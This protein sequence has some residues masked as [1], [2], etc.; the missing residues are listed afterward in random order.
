MTGPRTSGGATPTVA[1]VGRPGGREGHRIVRA[2]A[3]PDIG[4]EVCKLSRPD[5]ALLD[6]RSQVCA[7]DSERVPGGE[8][9]A[10]MDQAVQRP[11]RNPEVESCPGRIEPVVLVVAGHLPSGSPSH[12]L[13]AP[14]Q[15]ACIDSERGRQPGDHVETRVPLA[16]LQVADVR[17][18]YP[19]PIGQHLL[20][21]PQ[22]LAANTDTIAE[23]PLAG[24]RSL[25]G[26]SHP[27]IKRLR[28]I[29]VDAIGVSL[30]TSQREDW[31]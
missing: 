18:R 29:R 26:A 13:H 17:A 3:S 2:W 12:I 4:I 15:F 28:S 22:R 21:D 5:A 23:H 14:H 6:A 1:T 30:S 9:L 24:R 8:E 7:T 11:E 27:V 16:A 20:R 25:A 19:G 10:L 31:A